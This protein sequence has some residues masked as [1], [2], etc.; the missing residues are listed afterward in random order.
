LRLTGTDTP[1]A[2]ERR[3]LVKQRNELILMPAQQRAL[4]SL[5]K[6]LPAGDVFVLKA[7]SGA[8]RTTVLREL[9]A[10]VGGVFV[11][12][13]A[14]MHSLEGRD[15]LSVEEAFLTT[16]ESA[17]D[18]PDL[19]IV[20]DLHLVSNVVNRHNAARSLLL[21]AALT[22]I[23]GD[24]A[25]WGKKLVFG[26]EDEAPWP[27]RRRA[28][29]WEIRSLAVEDFA[30]ICRALL[31]T[32]MAERLDYAQ[33]HRFA[34]KLTAQQ[35]KNACRWL[36]RKERVDTARFIE[37]LRRRQLA[38]N[39]ALEEVQKV[40]W[41]DLKGVDGVIRELEAK[42]ALPFEN[43]ALT[44]E[45]KLK[46]KRG[47][48]L[49]GPPGTGKTTIGRALAHRLKSRFFLI[50]GTMVSG[51][52]DFQE[53]VEKIFEA[54]KRNAPSVV[55]IDDA[56]VIFENDGDR[57]L[58][59]YLLTVLD[60]LESESAARVCV[61]MTA[62]NAGALPAAL[63]RSGRVELWLETRLPDA[64]ARASILENLLAGLPEPLGKPDL[65]LL[66]EWSHG[67]TGAD[68]KNVVE[69]GK[70]LYAGDLTTRGTVRPAEAYYLEAIETVREN[71]R[72]YARSKPPKLTESVQ[73]GFCGPAA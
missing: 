51:S 42:I 30:C 50:D 20:D 70:L 59:R 6:A 44:A 29:T 25:A 62:M 47:V 33:I 55:F 13:G 4:K 61:M 8:G 53:E 49:A 72:N 28:Y 27:V 67:L 73:F 5:I 43:D 3:I 69:D 66:A 11:G 10:T 37:Y 32:A 52:Y 38:S 36:S 58:Y 40:N 15:P 35:L 56:D 64:P 22:A 18:G 63:L 45:L 65:N 39:V 7:A 14:I 57:G 16:I 1:V 26:V 2:R 41:R 19:V 9:H 34:P 71:R 24:A 46:P 54:A 17:L 60:G 21:D 31:P 48:L 12:I 23:M 68:L